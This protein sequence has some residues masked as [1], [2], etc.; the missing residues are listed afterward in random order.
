MDHGKLFYPGGTE[1]SAPD[2][3]DADTLKKALRPMGEWNT[4][5][6]TC[7][8]D[9]S[10]SVSVNGMLVAT[11]KTALTEGPVGWQSEGSEVHFRNIH[12]RE[13]K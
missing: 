4:T 11:G 6:V 5:E 13:M 8:P 10:V 1:K 3:F 12:I 2:T 7:K 9:G